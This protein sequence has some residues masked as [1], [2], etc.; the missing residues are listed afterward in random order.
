MGR[1]VKPPLVTRI[2]LATN[3]VVNTLN[4]NTVIAA[5]GVGFS[6]RIVGYHIYLTQNSAAGAI[7]RGRLF[8]PAGQNVGDAL[9][10]TGGNP[11]YGVIPEPGIALATNGALSI[12]TF[13]TAAAQLY[14]TV[15]YYYVDFIS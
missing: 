2:A 7:M 5:P 11:S 14:L 12:D 9:V 8:G 1:F 3:P 13:C 10:Q 15:V 6:L 4:T